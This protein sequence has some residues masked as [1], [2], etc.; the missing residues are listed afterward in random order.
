M[1]ARL[2]PLAATIGIFLLA[3]A[4][5]AIQFPAMLSTRVLGNLL[6]DN[7][8]LGIVAVGMTVVILSGGIDLSVG[9][10]I[11][12]S[13]VFIAAVLRD[14]GLHPLVVFAL[15]LAVTSAFGAAMGLLIHALAMPP[16]IVTLAGMFLARG[17][18]YLIT[19][20]SIPI[21]HPFFDWL[22]DLYWLMPGRGRFTL[23]AALM[24]LAV[25]AGIVVAHRTR[26]GTAVLAIGGGEQTARLIGVAIGRTTMLIYAFSGFMSGLAGIVFAIYTKS[27]YPL[28]TVGVELNAIAAVVIGG[29]LLTGG[30]GHVF[31]T[32]VGVLT[33]GLIQTYIVFDGTLSSWW[34]KIVVGLLLLLFIML[35][36]L[37]MRFGQAKDAVTDH[38]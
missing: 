30:A 26:F 8:Y 27:G 1:N 10:V 17:A 35:Q 21:T 13:G 34:T 18:G 32:L 25:G 33:M 23:L 5:S 31:G 12:F 14:T 24:L 4:V 36:N 28:A 38:A 29:T 3:Y 16:F 9:A 6:T 15:L 22:Q 19:I 20:D 37:L 7:A 2:L 11:A